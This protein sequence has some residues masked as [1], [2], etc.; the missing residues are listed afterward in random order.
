QAG[1]SGPHHRAT[2]SLAVGAAVTPYLDL[3][4]RSDVRHDR[5]AA[6]ALGPD[7]GTTVDVAAIARLGAELGS[8]WHVGAEARG[9]LPGAARTE[10]GSA[11]GFESRGLLSFLGVEN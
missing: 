10:R 7:T 4:L 6:D 9:V 1:T 3:A 8:D 11:V 2:S 5:H